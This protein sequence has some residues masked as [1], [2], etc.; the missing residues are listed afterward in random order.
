[1]YLA[2]AVTTTCTSNY[3]NLVFLADLLDLSVVG[4]PQQRKY[5]AILNIGSSYFAL[6]LVILLLGRAKGI[7]SCINA[8]STMYLTLRATTTL[9]YYNRVRF[10]IEE[11][12]LF[13]LGL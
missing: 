10:S 9:A 2:F 4:L 11:Y 13:A 12:I 8:A 7:F 5:L 3:S 1:V 6:R